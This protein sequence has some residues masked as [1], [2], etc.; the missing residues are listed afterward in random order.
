MT[1]SVDCR[2]WNPRGTRTI[3]NIQLSRQGAL[4]SDVGGAAMG[5]KGRASRK[6]PS[7]AT[8]APKVPPLHR[9]TSTRTH[10]YARMSIRTLPLAT[11]TA[12]AAA[13]AASAC[14][15]AT[16]AAT[17]A[18]ATT[19]IAAARAAVAG[20]GSVTAAS[21]RPATTAALA[22]VG[23]SGR[24]M[25]VGDNADNRDEDEQRSVGRLE[26]NCRTDNRCACDQELLARRTELCRLARRPDVRRLRLAEGSL[27]AFNRLL[28]LALELAALDRA[29]G[30]RLVVQLQP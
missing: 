21:R 28:V 29:A 12:A 24:D 15:A 3:A 25:D 19:S 14:T 7:F 16:T 13:S 23:R 6:E 1:R 2:A 22:Q 20:R 26:R 17:A 27:V 8:E 5:N 4:H 9:A 10:G 30:A 18:L 11:T